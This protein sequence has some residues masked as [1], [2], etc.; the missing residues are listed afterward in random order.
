MFI[1]ANLDSVEELIELVAG[2]GLSMALEKYIPTLKALNSGNYTK[3]DNVFIT[4]TFLDRII[5][6]TTKLELHPPRTD[7]IPIL[8]TLD[9]KHHKDNVTP[10]YNFCKVDWKEFKATLRANLP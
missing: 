4:D 6:C 7:H 9:I 10:R 3:P 1:S 2:H 8:T 5:H